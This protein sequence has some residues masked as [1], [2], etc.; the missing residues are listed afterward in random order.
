MAKTRFYRF[1]TGLDTILNLW[2]GNFLM[3][4]K[5]PVKFNG[6][7]FRT[8]DVLQISRGAWTTLRDHVGKSGLN[9]PNLAYAKHNLARIYCGK[10][11]FYMHN[12]H[13]CGLKNFYILA[14]P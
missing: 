2:P 8:R 12:D 6:Q 7:T 11:I 3:G 13:H 10:L 1:G 14:K 4:I 9:M 5:S